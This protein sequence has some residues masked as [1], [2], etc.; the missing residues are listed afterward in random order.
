MAA[1][2]ARFAALVNEEAAEYSLANDTSAFGGRFDPR[3]FGGRAVLDEHLGG[4]GSV[5]VLRATFGYD[6]T[7][8]ENLPPNGRFAG[9]EGVTH[10]AFLDG[11]SRLMVWPYPMSG[12]PGQRVSPQKLDYWTDAP[13]AT[14]GH[15]RRTSRPPSSRGSTSRSARRSVAS[16]AG[17][18]WTG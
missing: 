7:P 11:E 5:A 4:R 10:R 14:P 3:S 8:P 1:V 15:R 6:R 17:S 16:A 9:F 18:T 2:V 12:G 13:S